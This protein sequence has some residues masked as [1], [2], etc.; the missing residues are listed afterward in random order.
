MGL[1]PFG[2]PKYVDAIFKHLIDVKEDGSFVLDMS[3]FDF[4]VGSTMT[5]N[6]F[7]QLLAQHLELVNLKYLKKKWI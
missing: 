4:A 3:Y 5:N 2:E 6:K 1:A 7:H